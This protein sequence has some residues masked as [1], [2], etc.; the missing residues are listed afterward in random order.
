MEVTFVDVDETCRDDVRAIL[1]FVTKSLKRELYS[2]IT[3]VIVTFV[4]ERWS[5][6]GMLPVVENVAWFLGIRDIGFVGKFIENIVGRVVG[7]MDWPSIGAR[8]LILNCWYTNRDIML[9]LVETLAR[10]Y[11][12]RHPDT[13]NEIVNAFLDESGVRTLVDELVKTVEAMP[14]DAADKRA[15]IDEVMN[16]LDRL[17]NRAI[18]YAT[19]ILA[20][21]YFLLMNTKPFDRII[22]MC[23]TLNEAFFAPLDCAYMGMNIRCI[24][25]DMLSSA[26]I[27]EVPLNI[28]RIIHEIKGKFLDLS[29]TFPRFAQAVHKLFN[30]V[31]QRPPKE[32]C[33]E[34]GSRCNNIFKPINLRDV[35]TKGLPVM[36]EL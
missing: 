13:T 28:A 34:M 21:N 32:V 24:I 19:E 1:E 10:R 25:N 33:R 7:L 30:E 27:S 20:A 31:V 23:K 29:T 26:N 4:D 12:I 18:D 36:D 2:D 9:S 17:R 3:H 22:Q 6:D 14:I 11:L 15:R 16:D 8:F 5:Y 35:R